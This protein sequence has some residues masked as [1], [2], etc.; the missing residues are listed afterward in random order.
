MN[1]NFEVLEPQ[2]IKNYVKDF[3]LIEESIF[4]PLE[5]GK[6]NFFINH[7]NNYYPFFT[8]QG[9]K[10]RF[11]AIKNESKIIGTAVG[12][13]KKIF[14]NGY[15]YT[16]LYIADLKIELE[17]RKKGILKKIMWDLII[18]WPFIKDYQ[19]W[20]FC[21]FCTMLKNNQGVEKSFKGLTPAKLAQ[22]TGLI[23]IYMINPKKLASLKLTDMPNTSFKDSINLSPKRK[24]LVLWNNGKKDIVSSINNTVF[25][26]GHLHPEIILSENSSNIK[27]AISIIIKNDG[28]ACFAID[29]RQAKLIDWLKSKGIS[30]NTKCKIFS[31][32]PFAPS[33][34]KFDNIFI[35]T[36]E[37]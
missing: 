22:H 19:G 8:Q 33:I 24:E 2:H 10:T 13:W 15:Q 18:R 27:K 3:K 32:S 23:N 7:G 4:Y 21:F 37:I 29:N 11:V 31:F 14:F 34:K 5:N 16:G 12:V 1:Y 28:I 9:N 6:G 25:N 26:F 17:H 36:G 20:D 35:S 30:T